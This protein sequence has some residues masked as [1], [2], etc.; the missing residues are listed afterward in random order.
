MIWKP[1]NNAELYKGWLYPLLGLGGGVLSHFCSSLLHV[2]T[3]T[4]IYNF[5]FDVRIHYL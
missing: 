5:C 2:H 4:N 3:F 1:C